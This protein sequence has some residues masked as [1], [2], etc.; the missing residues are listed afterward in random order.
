M[1]VLT[2]FAIYFTGGL[3]LLACNV[4]FFSA[5]YQSVTGGNLVVAPVKVVGGTGDPN[6][7]GE[8]LARLII[9]RLQ[10]LQ[11][12]LKESQSSLT[13][14]NQRQIQAQQQARPAASEIALPR[15]VAAG[16][17][18]IPQTAALNAQL[19]EPTTIDVKVAGVDVGGL[20]PGIQRWFVHD[21]TLTFAVSMDGTSAIVAGNIDPLAP[22]KAKPIWMSVKNA[23]PNAIAD[24]IALALI[25][26]RW[27]TDSPQ[28]RELSDDEF[29]QL[30]ESINGT[31][32]ANR[33]F[34]I[35]GD[36][37][38]PDF[39]KISDALH[40]LADRMVS[41]NELTSFAA[42]IAESAENYERALSYY[43]RL[44]ASPKPGLDP[45]TLQAKISAIEAL[46][47]KL[48]PAAAKLAPAATED[49]ALKKMRGHVADATRILNGLFNASLPEPE[50]KLISDDQRNAYWDG[51]AINVP[52]S[53]QDIPDVIYHEVAWPFVQSRWP[54]FKYEGQEG[55]LVQSYT[56]VLATLVKQKK[57]NQTASTAD[58]VIAP[59][60]MA[61]IEGKPD[62]TDTRPLRSM[63]APGT[64]YDRDAQSNHFSKLYK[65]PNTAA[66][67]FGGV[68][69]NSGIPNRAFYETA[70][71]IGTDSAGKIWIASLDQFKSPTDLRTAAKVILETATKLNGADS[72]ET[73]SVKA[74][75]DT[76][77]L[78]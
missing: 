63:K 30:V 23:N 66:G 37:A 17:L 27:A 10:A 7:A 9:A 19:F 36:E 45:Q 74:A 11:W 39:V 59:G 58:W 25:H 40:P 29:S 73:N 56:D 70:M 53:V 46:A 1:E 6:L 76:V 69:I 48:G 16:M 50:L 42:S 21:K 72:K 3:A 20:L 4:W 47:A 22:G 44:A 67:D 13:S 54:K 5:V 8:A 68:H 2:K 57:L 28:Y 15:G 61:W 49:V 14:E 71:K 78:L 38:K 32:K 65:A 60:A 33:R 77:G 43:R 62:R 18:G 55:A 51:T 41:W 12:D 24:A 34:T 52:P 31:A 75:L 35:Y 26:R 64:A